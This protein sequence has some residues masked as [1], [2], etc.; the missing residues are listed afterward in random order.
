MPRNKT[1][2]K[3]RS[4]ST[5]SG[6]RTTTQK[7]TIRPYVKPPCLPPNYYNETVPPLLQETLCLWNNNNNNSKNKNSTTGSLQNAY[8]AVVTLVRHQYGPQLYK[9][10]IQSLEQAVAFALQDNHH[11][12][13]NSNTN[14]TNSS[15]STRLLLHR[16]PLLYQEFLDYLTACKHVFAPLDRPHVWNAETNQAVPLQQQP[17]AKA[18]ATSNTNTTNPAAATPNSSTAMTNTSQHHHRNNSRCH[19]LWTAGLL[20]FGKRL[21]TLEWIQPLYQQWLDCLLQDWHDDETPSSSMATADH[22]SSFSARHD[23]QAVWYMWQDLGLLTADSPLPLQRDL[24]QHWRDYG[25]TAFTTSITLAT[26]TTTA[27]PMAFLHQAQACHAHVTQWPWLPL[28]WL[29]HILDTQLVQPQLPAILQQLD[30]LLRDELASSKAMTMT[31]NASSSS[32]WSSSS[33]NPGSML[34]S[35]T[36]T[37][38]TTSNSHNSH[39]LTPFGILWR[40]AGRLPKGHA[41]VT[42]AVCTWMKQEGLRRLQAGGVLDLW[43]LQQAA[44][45]TKLSNISFK[46][47][48]E[49]VVNSNGNV[50]EQLAKCLDQILRSNKKLD[51]QG[52]KLPDLIHGLFVPLQAKDVFE[53]FYKRDLAKR[54]L[55]NRCVSMDVEKQVCSLFKAECGAGYTSKMEGMF[56]DIDL[57]RE[58]MMLYKQSLQQQQQLQQPGTPNVDM[59]VQILTTGYWPVYPQYPNL[60]LPESLLHM[61]SQFDTHYKKKCHGRRIAWQYALGHCIV[62]TQGFS[63]S[64]ELVVSL[65]QALVLEKFESDETVWTL[66]ALMKAVGMEDRDEMERILQ[67]LALGKEGTRILRKIDHK[68]SSKP[69]MTVHDEDQ[70]RIQTAFSSNQ[71]RIRIQNILM[72][73]T[74]EERQ[75]TVEAVSRDRLY[76]MDAVVVRIMKARKTVLHQQLIPQVLEQVKFPAQASDV[77]KRIESLIEREYMERDAKDRNRYNYLA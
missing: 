39:N 74:K 40:L 10:W 59:E 53:A 72:K 52:P 21:E 27:Q 15:D 24:E 70:F 71:R 36:T 16:I 11:N 38:T 5:R 9:D 7:I 8:M 22:P 26:T 17:A 28:H 68:P 29:W 4:T 55:W 48:W 58:N 41:A 69:R 1:L 20:Y 19:T 50:A 25:A 12:A 67:S 60:H 33:G 43:D 63:K 37:A 6:K 13:I 18:T 57:S 47:V 62:R 35:S 77:K 49:E 31:A 64:Y 56:Q 46:Q 75:K 2:L 65:C 14:T 76:L 61:Q 3:G 51:L 45:D 30:P 44:A 23:L 32:R 34:A 54:L 42:A 73:E 66:P